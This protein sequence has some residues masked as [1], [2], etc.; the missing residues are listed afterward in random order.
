M[1][2]VKFSKR[3]LLILP[4]SLGRA[5]G[6]RE[7]DRVE[8]QRRE[9]VLHLSRQEPLHQPGPLTDLTQIVT[10]SHPAGSVDVESFMDKHGYEQVYARASF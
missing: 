4:E 3:Q 9:R 8:I 10:S 6:L 7:G 5:L 1:V 2:T